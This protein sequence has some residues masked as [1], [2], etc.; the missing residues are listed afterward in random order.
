MASALTFLTRYHNEGEDFLKIIVTGDETRVLYDNPETK[1]Q[2]KQWM[3]T[4]SP[5]KPRKFKQTLSNRKT[6]FG[7]CVITERIAWPC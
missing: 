6:S 1:E 3:H 4:D 7:V 5:S 2:S